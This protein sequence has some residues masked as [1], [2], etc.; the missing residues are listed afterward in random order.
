MRFILSLPG[1][2]LLLLLCVGAPAS[3]LAQDFSI[4]GYQELNGAIERADNARERT[5]EGSDAWVRATEEAL[6]TRTAALDYLTAWIRSGTMPEEL[7]PT[8]SQARIL[9]MQNQIVL[10][11][12]LGRCDVARSQ[13]RT[14]EALVDF[15]NEEARESFQIAE[16]RVEQCRTRTVDTR[17]EPLDDPTPLTDPSRPEP[18]DSGPNTVGLALV[19]SGGAV[20]IGSAIYWATLMSA[21]SEF[22]PIQRACANQRN[23]AEDFAFCQENSD[24]GDQLS[25]RLDVGVPLATGLTIVGVGLTGVGV[26]MLVRGSGSDDRREAFL[27]PV[28]TPHYQGLHL[29]TRF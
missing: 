28:V 6:E 13:L 16:E 20:L 12:S 19:G 15:D 14:V 27:Q 24:R 17:P 23:S 3:A 25:R 11:A 5:R 9:L 29:R 4:E 22:R 1:A 7:Q 21:D 18:S 8:A 26:A 10:N 2:M